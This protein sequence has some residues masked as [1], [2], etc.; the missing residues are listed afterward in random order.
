MQDGNKF[1]D[2]RDTYKLQAIL[3][4]NDAAKIKH[5]AKPLQTFKQKFKNTTYKKEIEAKDHDLMVIVDE[6]QS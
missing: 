6:H 4:S 1:T 2:F 5:L 3:S